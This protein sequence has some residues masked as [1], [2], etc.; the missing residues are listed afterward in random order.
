MSTNIGQEA[1]GKQNIGGGR[2]DLSPRLESSMDDKTFMSVH[3]SQV[4][5]LKVWS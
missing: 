5:E 1:T 3:L 2:A 4:Q